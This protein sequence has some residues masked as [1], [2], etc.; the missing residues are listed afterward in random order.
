[1]KKRTYLI[2]ILIAFI[3]YQCINFLFFPDDPGFLRSRIHPYWIVILLIACRYGFVPG[4]SAGII[5]SAYM[6]VFIFGGIPTRSA[7]E[8]LIESGGFI[9]P[10]AFML[11]GMFLG[12]IRQK[13]IDK[14]TRC[15]IE[16]DE[17]DQTILALNEN[18]DAIE[19]ARRLL[20]ARIVGE[21][22][23]IKTLHSA[24]S[25]LD[26]LQASSIY[27]GCLQ[28]LS[29]HFQVEKAS[30]YLQEGPYYVLKASSGYSEAEVVEGKISVEKSI[31][32]IAFEQNK[33]VTVKDILL[34][35]DSNK[36]ITQYGQVMAMIPIRDKDKR[37]LGV[38]NIEKIDFLY[39]NMTNIQMM[40]LVV[41]WVSRALYNKQLYESAVNQ[42]IWDAELGIYSY[43]HFYAV[44]ESEFI[45]A[46]EYG[47]GL[48]VSL[49]K[50]DKFGFYEMH[51]QRLISKAVVATIKRFISR[52][53]MLFRFRYDGTFAIISPIKDKQSL[54]SVADAIR[55]E[56]R[57]GPDTLIRDINLLMASEDM[58]TKSDRPEGLLAPLIKELNMK[59]V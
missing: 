21:T 27:S 17:K 1:M 50:I 44:L 29:E 31:M 37:P 7:L 28:I 3:I 57:Q 22:T 15:S 35:R 19:K 20:E 32:S 34:H 52:T 10:L 14:E 24:A 2:E 45:R 5:S 49:L 6:L 47:L 54:A 56:L 46:K 36:Y 4:I 26:T 42:M 53:D 43:N 16:S 55:G 13:Y 8:Q 12:D 25:K 33:T 18:K 39:F 11:V 23:T 59:I 58:H 48:T 38:V 9:L 40:E 51:A 30:V 41:D